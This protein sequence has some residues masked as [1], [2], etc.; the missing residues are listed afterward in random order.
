MMC[1]PDWRWHVMEEL[2][3]A[4]AALLV[5]RREEYI[6]HPTK[7]ETFDLEAIRALNKARR[8]SATKELDRGHDILWEI[9][10][11]QRAE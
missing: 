5:A 6:G 8:I 9:D 3:A 1:D 10:E 2:T 7:A 4:M 11:A